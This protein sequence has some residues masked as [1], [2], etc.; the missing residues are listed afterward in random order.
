VALARIAGQPRWRIGVRHILPNVANSII[1][2]ATLDLGR[3][4]ILESSLSFLGLGVQPPEVS[5]G[6][7]LADG[8]AYMTVAWW[9]TVMPGLAILLAVLSLN[10]FG[11]WLRDRLD[12]RQS[13]D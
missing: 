5:W 12:P 9:L 1:V 10:I 3:V 6:L 13:R 11:D 2:L 8:R 7:M 4:I